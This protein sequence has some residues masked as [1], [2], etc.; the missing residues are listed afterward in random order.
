M[1]RRWQR[2]P[3]P[4]AWRWLA[5]LLLAVT[6]LGAASASSPFIRSPAL[7]GAQVVAQAT[8]ELP[9]SS[10]VWRLVDR[11]AQPRGVAQPGKR[12]LGFVVP[13]EGP[14]LLTDVTAS[15]LEDVARV[16]PGEFYL[17]R[18]G[19]DQIR[20]SLSETPV[21][22]LTLELVPS[23]LATD[24][25]AGSLIARSDPLTAPSGER[26]FD[27][28][29]NNLAAGEQGKVPNTG[30]P[31]LICVTSGT[32]RINPDHGT[33]T[34]ITLG[35]FALFDPAALTISPAPQSAVTNAMAVPALWQ[36]TSA[37][38]TTT[39]AGY[40]AAVFGPEIQPPPP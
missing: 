19:T 31:V 28:V 2:I 15:G 35:Q 6:P 27:L 21:H 1:D 13:V 26:D 12:V 20:A 11:V 17:V 40:V 9:A 38:A 24:V 4:G 39:V 34:T 25:G 3:R 32:I 10:V 8:L 37:P 5:L 36:N 29:A 22:Y 14:V 23:D 18:D 33:A 16:A 30:Q 7:G